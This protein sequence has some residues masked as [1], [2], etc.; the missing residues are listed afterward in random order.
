MEASISRSVTVQQ[1]LTDTARRVVATRPL[2]RCQSEAPCE[3]RH[4]LQD[5]CFRFAGPFGGVQTPTTPR[6][7]RCSSSFSSSSS[8]TFLNSWAGS[9]P[10][11]PGRSKADRQMAPLHLHAPPKK[12]TQY[13]VPMVCSGPHPSSFRF[14]KEVSTNQM[15][16]EGFNICA[17]W[18]LLG[19]KLIKP[20]KPA[21]SIS[22]GC[23]S[24]YSNAC[25]LH[26]AVVLYYGAIGDARIQRTRPLSPVSI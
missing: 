14:Q 13:H 6:P 4:H 7:N 11:G 2:H 12:N 18:N 22:C 1:G 19:L 5:K 17:A 26:A 15:V 8:R 3:S 9:V 20:R 10:R 23:L 25:G 16:N 24:V 21:N